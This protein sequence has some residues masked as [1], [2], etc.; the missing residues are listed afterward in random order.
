MQ[1]YSL[2]LEVVLAGTP[3]LAAGEGAFVIALAGMDA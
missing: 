1:V 2:L 3:S